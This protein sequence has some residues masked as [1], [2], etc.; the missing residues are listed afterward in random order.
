M[1][2]D[3]GFGLGVFE[4]IWGCFDKRFSIDY[5]VQPE[6]NLMVSEMDRVLIHLFVICLLCVAINLFMSFAFVCLILTA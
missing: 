4:K 1:G 2:R 5:G 6:N 3:F